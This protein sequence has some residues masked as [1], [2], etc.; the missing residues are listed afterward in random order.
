MISNSYLFRLVVLFEDCCR[1]VELHERFLK[2]KVGKYFNMYL[3]C[4]WSMVVLKSEP[5]RRRLQQLPWEPA[6]VNVSENNTS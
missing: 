6:D 1:K 2:L 5:E 3:S 4:M